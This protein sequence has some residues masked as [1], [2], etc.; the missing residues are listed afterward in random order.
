MAPCIINGMAY[1]LLLWLIFF[2]R[3]ACSQQEDHAK[4]KSM[5]SF[6]SSSSR[7]NQMKKVSNDESSDVK[8]EVDRPLRLKKN[9][10]PD[11]FLVGAQK[12][13][14]SSL[15]SLLMSSPQICH[16]GHAKWVDD[17]E[18]HYFDYDPE[19]EKGSKHYV[20]YFDV[21]G[22]NRSMLSIDPTP[23]LHTIPKV[24]RRINQTYT[25]SDMKKKKL[26]IILRDPVYRD[27]S[28]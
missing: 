11:V 14:T 16:N 12:C 21:P 10:P 9:S 3:F 6:F 13:G 4:E 17:K 19:F 26:I 22:C 2:S 8:S 24:P 7:K 20:K 28:W 23:V 15:F 18:I 1:R 5:F 27:Y 25:R